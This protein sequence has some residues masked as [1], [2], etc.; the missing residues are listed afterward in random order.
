MP[1]RFNDCVEKGG[2]VRTIKPSEGTHQ[3]I[4][5]DKQGSHAGEVKK[6]KK[7]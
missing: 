1:K 3:K 2:R 6:T 5:F 7:K 4:C